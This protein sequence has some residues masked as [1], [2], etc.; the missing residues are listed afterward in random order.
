MNVR[1]STTIVEIGAMFLTAA[2]VPLHGQTI[3]PP[4]TCSATPTSLT[5]FSYEL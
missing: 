4:A 3:T 1:L 5:A 2:M